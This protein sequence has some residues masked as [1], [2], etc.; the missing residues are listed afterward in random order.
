MELAAQSGDPPRPPLAREVEP[1]V[2]LQLFQR[3]GPG[4]QHQALVALGAFRVAKVRPPFEL[5]L[6]G[7][8]RSQ[9]QPAARALAAALG[10]GVLRPEFKDV[11]W[12]PSPTVP[13]PG[14]HQP[15]QRVDAAPGTT[16]SDDEVTGATH[17]GNHR[18]QR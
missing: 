14:E 11:E 9:R 1:P 16:S 15:G 8:D 5:G 7:I 10:A 6:R 13:C 17:A 4:G 3:S 18:M 12:L 2:L